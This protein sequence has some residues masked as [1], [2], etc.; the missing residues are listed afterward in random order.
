MR[1]I[2]SAPCSVRE[3]EGFQRPDNGFSASEDEA[4]GFESGAPVD[5]NDEVSYDSEDTDPG[6]DIDAD[7]SSG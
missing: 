5:E 2:S 6:I 7:K 4:P 1:G 3:A